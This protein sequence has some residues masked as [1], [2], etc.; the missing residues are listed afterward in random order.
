M[1]T[2]PSPAPTPNPSSPWTEERCEE[3]KSLECLLSEARLIASN[4]NQ[5]NLTSLRAIG[6]IAV[7]MT[8]ADL[9][10]PRPSF[11]DFLR[12]QIIASR[13]PKGDA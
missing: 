12:D 1:K 8:T 11:I 4:P 5:I 13:F 9:V 2:E 7:A 6:R 3:F 10:E